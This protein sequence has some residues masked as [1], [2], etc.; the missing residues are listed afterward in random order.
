MRRNINHRI[1]AALFLAALAMEAG[2]LSRNGNVPLLD[3][4]MEGGKLFVRITFPRPPGAVFEAWCYESEVTPEGIPQK[5]A[6]GVLVLLHRGVRNR[7]LLIETT[8]TPSPGRVAF[9]AR[10]VMDRKLSPDA[11][12]P[13]RL[14]YLNLCF[15]ETRATAFVDPDEPFPKFIARH[16]IFTEK[17][18]TSVLDVARRENEPRGIP[19]PRTGNRSP[20]QCLNVSRH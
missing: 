19:R 11:E 15:Q 8:V 20:T 12:V 4:R 6:D 16:F 5:R 18:R 14:P 13:R 7:N 3:S 2:T 9:S 17:G 1:S 10:P